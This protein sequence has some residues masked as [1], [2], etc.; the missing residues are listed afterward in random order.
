[1]PISK[2]VYGADTIIDITDTTATASDVSIG[3]YFYLPNGVRTEGTAA[4]G[5]GMVVVETTD[6]H[7]GTIVSISG[8]VIRLQTKTATPSNT[9]IYV[10]PDGGYIGLSSVAISAI[11]SQYVIP[12]GTINIANNGIVDVSAYAS[13]NVNVSGGVVTLQSKSINPDESAH[14]VTADAGYTA[15]STVYVGAISSTYIGSSITRR[16]IGDIEQAGSEITI[17][18]GYYAYD[19]GWSL[20]G[21]EISVGVIGITANPTISVD[22]NGLITASVIGGTPVTP[23][24]DSSGYFN[25]AAGDSVGTL[26]AGSVSVYGSNSTQLSTEAGKTVTPTT[27]EQTAV[28]AGKYTTGA[29]KV[30]AM[31]SGTAG[32]PTATKGTVSNHSISVTPS[33]TNTTGYITGGTKSGTA[34]T[35]SASELV[36]GT[37]SITA[38]GSTDVT[39]YK[40]AS[41]S[42]GTATTPAKTISVTPGITLNSSTGAISVS[43]AGSSS[44]TP[45]VSAGYVSSGTAGTI[46]V[47]GSSSMTLT[48]KAAATVYPSTADQTIASR[49]YLTGAQTIKAV[50]TTN[51]SAA[52]IKQGVT[53]QVGDSTNSSRITSVAGT[54]TSD[55]TASASDILSGK[56]AYASGSKLTGTLTISHYYTGSGTPSAGLGVNGDIYLKTS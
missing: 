46:T 34:V 56:T 21:G 2:V 8:E 22:S 16:D 49:Y 30:A 54:F 12:S 3:K 15:L 33:V 26:T 6:E 44:V 32:T 27:S 31:P 20:E 50:T 42:A 29:I 24:L 10:T 47:S 25:D 48:T 40:Y 23:K 52:N 41:V 13:A 35:V 38:S 55:A 36:S 43:V 5:S 37:K 45:T 9:Q 14:T 7:G 53:V 19:C 51:L 28:A 17:P 39:N 18:R 1:M 4:Q 11:P